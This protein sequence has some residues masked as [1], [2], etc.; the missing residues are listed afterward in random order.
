MLR[1]TVQITGFK[2]NAYSK[3]VI[4]NIMSP[5]NENSGR[6]EKAQE[7]DRRDHVPTTARNEASPGSTQADPASLQDWTLDEYRGYC[8]GLVDVK[9]FDAMADNGKNLAVYDRNRFGRDTAL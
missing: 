8:A 2:S 4:S 5:D 6:V 1:R 9:R 7:R 3:I